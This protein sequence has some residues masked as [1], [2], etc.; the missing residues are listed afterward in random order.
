M[1]AS[2]FELPRVLVPSTAAELGIGRARMRT[3]VRRDNWRLMARGA[4][5]TRPEE[6]TRADWAAVGIAFGGPSAALSGWDAL[7][8]RGLG[9]PVPPANEVLVLSGH[10]SN[11]RIGPLRIRETRRAYS[12]HLT[13]VDAGDYALFPVVP[14]HRAVADASRY[15]SALP[16]LRALVTS[17]VQRRGCTLEQ[18]VA[19]IRVGPRNYSALFRVA[20]SDA[21]DGARSEAEARAA[22][23][24]AREPLPSFELNVPIV[25][26]DGNELGVVDALWR[27]LR[28]V[29]E[30]DSREYHF[31]ERDWKKTMA[32]H[33]RLTRCGLALTHYPPS[34]VNGRGRGWLDEIG[35]WLR[36]RALELDV[37]WR[38]GRGVLRPVGEPV[39]FV[40]GRRGMS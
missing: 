28:A 37:P 26:A 22:R 35:E 23:R 32:R 6:P 14:V 3:E 11:R 27:E 21:L 15:Y 30:I 20:L 16:P 31:S 33:N 5:L 1:L 24:L 13:S 7:R 2:T 39:P 18:L 10:A 8:V 12:A 9:A 29:L 19:E 36:A 38:R 17:A 34:D 25:D 40:I 4:I